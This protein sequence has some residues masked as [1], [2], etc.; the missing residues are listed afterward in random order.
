MYLRG[1]LGCECDSKRLRLGDDPSLLQLTPPPAPGWQPNWGPSDYATPAE[2]FAA[3]NVGSQPVPGQTTY[4]NF[5]ATAG[6]LGLSSTSLLLLGGLGLL[7]IVL[8]SGGRRRR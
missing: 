3:S 4:S 6:S 5:N 7:G 8:L 2:I 1:R